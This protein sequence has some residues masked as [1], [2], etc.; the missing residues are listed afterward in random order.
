MYNNFLQTLKESYFD[1]KIR[2]MELGVSEE[3]I[4]EEVRY[5][6]KQGHLYDD[7]FEDFVAFVEDTNKL[8]HEDYRTTKHRKT[9]RR[10]NYE[11]K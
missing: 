6:W 10:T 2:N 8:L 5:R 7:E 4:L 11:C 1:I 3:A 9:R